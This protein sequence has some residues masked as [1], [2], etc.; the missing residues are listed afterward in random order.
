MQWILKGGH[1]Y[2]LAHLV[3]LYYR[4]QSM[5]RM[6]LPCESC[7]VGLRLTGSLSLSAF[8][9][10]CVCVMCSCRCGT[11]LQANSHYEEV[12]RNEEKWPE[13]KTA[14]TLNNKKY[15]FVIEYL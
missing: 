8:V 4:G 12:K 9:C 15:N 11:L 2:S 14:W 1:D 3:L 10:V 13:R 6:T 7:E 5:L